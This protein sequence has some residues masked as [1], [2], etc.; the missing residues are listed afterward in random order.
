M[1][2]TDIF[3]G[4]GAS[5]TKVPELDLYCPIA[6]GGSE[7]TTFT[8][9]TTVTNNF[10]LVKNLYVGCVLHRYNASNVKQTGT[11]RVT[12]NDATTVTFTPAV[13]TLAGDDYFVIDSYGAP[14]PAPKVA[15]GGST[16]TAGVTTVT[17]TSDVKTDYDDTTIVLNVLPSEGGTEAE[18]VVFIDHDAAATYSG[19]I[20]SPAE[21]DISGAS[22][23]TR[24]EYAAIFTIAVNTLSNVT[25]TRN[26]A[27]VTITNDFKGASTISH[28]LGLSGSATTDTGITFTS[29]LG[30]T[31]SST[32]RAKL[33]ADTWLGIVENVTFPTTEVEM[34]QNNLSLGGSRNWTYQ[35]KGIETAGAADLGIVANHGSWLYYFFGKC[36][37]ITATAAGA[38]PASA[39]AGASDSVYLETGA[40]TE[41]GPLFRRTVGTVMT[42]PV[43]PA[44]EDHAEMHLVTAPAQASTTIQN[45]ITYT[46][47]EQQGDLLPSF[48]L[49][50]VFSKLTSSTDTYVTSTDNA[51]EDLNF[52]KIARGCKVNTLNI[53]ANENEEVKMQVNANTKNV[54]V[55]EKTEAYE[56]RNGVEDETSFFNFTAVD[57]FREPFFFSDGTFKIFGESFLK[58]TTLAL[59]MSN[60]L[61]DKRFLGVGNKSI[62]EAI[63]GQRTYEL[64]FTGYVTDS[65]LYNELISNTE[66]T[67]QNIEL[68]FAKSNGEEINLTFSHYLLSANEFPMADDKGPIEV[69]ATVMP[70]K[71][72]SCTVKTHWQLQG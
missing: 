35:Y 30:T 14:C 59:N 68:K 57:D 65:R 19:G 34:K 12:S 66:N 41:T 48:A 5:I 40:V 46:F 61:V 22:N 55:L 63:P 49:E 24:E 13:A 43:N 31:V 60:S 67:T 9:N 8:I 72:A 20:S 70:R 58:I 28:H 1:A 10:S 39:F 23:N 62:Q 32:G 6:S 3:L 11:H 18:S 16:H 26:G 54:H 17:F 52:V 38:A 71:L 69:T 47:E 50:Q 42:P 37:D 25:A 4:S 21:A 7:V 64:T 27:V 53:T 51:N 29:T 33:L 36:T 56:A 2:N 44:I 45:D 15:T